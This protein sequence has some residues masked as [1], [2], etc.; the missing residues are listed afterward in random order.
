MLPRLSFCIKKI[1]GL[2]ISP[3]IEYSCQVLQDAAE[4]DTDL[5]LVACVKLQA[6]VESINGNTTMRS[7]SSDGHKAPLWM[8]T[9]SGR[10][11]IQ[12]VLDS[13]PPNLQNNGQ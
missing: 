4:L 1:D 9:A 11:D 10:S 3:Y 7:P 2:P 12:N 8:H 13:L 6:I 5:I